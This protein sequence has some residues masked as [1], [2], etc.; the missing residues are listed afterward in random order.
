MTKSER[1]IYRA[2]KRKRRFVLESA[3]YNCWAV[4]HYYR[5]GDLER[6]EEFAEMYLQD[7]NELRQIDEQIQSCK[8]G[9]FSWVTI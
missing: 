6:W 8:K 5:D 1:Q 9:D 2:L 7:V 4:G 3:N